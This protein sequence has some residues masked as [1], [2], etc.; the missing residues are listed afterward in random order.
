MNNPV[1]KIENTFGESI[2]ITAKDDWVYTVRV[3]EKCSESLTLFKDV[4]MTCDQL[5]ALA[6]EIILKIKRPR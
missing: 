6:N 4:R 5:H 3:A 2:I 1:V